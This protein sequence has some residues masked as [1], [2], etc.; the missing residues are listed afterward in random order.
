MTPLFSRWTRQ[1]YLYRIGAVVFFFVV[2][3][4]SFY[5]GATAGPDM[6][7]FL[8]VVIACFLVITLF[9][10][11]HVFMGLLLMGVAGGLGWL[12]DIWGV[13]NELWT[14]HGNENSFFEMHAEAA[15][16]GVPIE[17]VLA[18]FFSAMWL[19]QVLESL[20][21]EEHD[22]MHAFHDAGKK[23][24]L[25]RKEWVMGASITAASVLVVLVDPLYL[26]PLIT[27]NIGT[28]LT[29]FVPAAVRHTSVVFGVVMAISG[30][31]FEMLCT[32]KLFPDVAIWTYS[33]MGHDLPLWMLGVFLGYAG[34]GAVVASAQLLLLRNSIFG[35]RKELLPHPSWI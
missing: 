6:R 21:D 20:F 8:I 25:G 17:I 24:G 9:L 13:T 30:L 19:M 11:R 5:Q 7:A 14:Y 33:E 1:P 28:W 27:F 22:W 2:M 34:S 12:T 18:Y 35:Q 23:L 15:S 10:A 31:F 26:Q 32:G 3:A 16:G 29:L 4:V